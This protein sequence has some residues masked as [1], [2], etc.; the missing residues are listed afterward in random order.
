M[1]SHTGIKLCSFLLVILSSLTSLS[2]QAVE[3]VTFTSGQPLNQY[4]PS[5]IIP[6]LTEAFKRNG[7]RFK[8]VHHP[9]LRSLLYSSTGNLD[10]ELHRVYDFHKVSGGKYPDL[11]RIESELITTWLAI[12]STK[13]IPFD[14]WKD[15]K[16]YKV[17]YSRGKKI[18]DNLLPRFL[19]KEQ[20]VVAN[21]DTDAFKMLSDGLVDVVIAGSKTGVDLLEAHNQF[22][23]ITKV[24]NVHPIRMYSYI[25][26][27]HQQLAAKIADTLEQMKKDGS[28]AKIVGAVNNSSKF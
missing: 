13:K 3:N 19:P 6:I 8:A 14:N 24:Q 4:V 7:I 5:T 15:L 12:Y 17:S 11:I 2:S 20:I 18:L 26:K 27:K 1:Q 16:E 21:N 9:S 23:N 10:G 22:S 28:Y 25:H